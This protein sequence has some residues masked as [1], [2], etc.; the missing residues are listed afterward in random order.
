MSNS[1]YH[2]STA[3]IVMTIVLCFTAF[4]IVKRVQQQDF[5]LACLQAGGSVGVDHEEPTC[6][7][8]GVAR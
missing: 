2:W 6:T 8:A 4:G 7:G 5:R 1:A 3:A